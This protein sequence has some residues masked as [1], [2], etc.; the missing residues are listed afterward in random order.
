MTKAANDALIQ[1]SLEKETELFQENQ[2][3]K[4]EILLIPGINKREIE[5]HLFEDNI[6]DTDSLL[7]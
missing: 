2:W 3:Y 4:K 1:S 5:R 6:A 7:L